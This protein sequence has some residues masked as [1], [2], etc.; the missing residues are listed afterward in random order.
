MNKFK[1]VSVV[2]T[3]WDL[4]WTRARN[5]PLVLNIC[6]TNTY[7]GKC[8]Y[9]AEGKTNQAIELYIYAE[10]MASHP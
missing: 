6:S 9:E 4:I 8:L 1:E 2:I 10:L 3:L 5:F 7:L